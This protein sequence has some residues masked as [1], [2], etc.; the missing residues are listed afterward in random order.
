MDWCESQLAYTAD[1]L[2][3]NFDDK[4]SRK[5]VDRPLTCH[6]SSRLSTFAF[7]SGEVRRLLLDFGPYGGIDQL[8]MFPLFLKNC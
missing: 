6:Q 8:G 4:Q 2:L 5:Y 3:D 1:L 7:R